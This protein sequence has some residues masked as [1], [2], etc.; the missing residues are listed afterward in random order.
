MRN[1]NL[2]PTTVSTPSIPSKTLHASKRANIRGLRALGVGVA[3]GL[4]SIPQTTYAAAAALPQLATMETLIATIISVFCYIAAIVLIGMSAWEY[5]THRKIALVIGE[6]IG[7]VVV[8]VIALNGNNIATA[9]GLSAASV[10]ALHVAPA[11]AA[12]LTN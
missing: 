3:A 4:A 12:S 9:L 10:T 5:M 11:I 1:P 8:V 7:A 2:T 6:V